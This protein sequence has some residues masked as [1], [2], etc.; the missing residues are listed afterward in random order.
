M[1]AKD[2]LI[3]FSTEYANP[4]SSKSSDELLDEYTALLQAEIE[5]VIGED[6]TLREQ[7]DYDKTDIPHKETD[8]DV[9]GSFLYTVRQATRNGY[10]NDCRHRL[11]EFM[12]GSGE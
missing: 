6:E 9:Y 3:E 1:K 4:D 8:R 5:K 7:S 11:R 12:K 10:R 2:I